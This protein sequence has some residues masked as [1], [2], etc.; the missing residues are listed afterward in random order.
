MAIIGQIYFGLYGKYIFKLFFYDIIE[1]FE[2]NL[3]GIFLWDNDLPIVWFSLCVYLKS[4][5]TVSTDCKGKM[6]I[7]PRNYKLD[8]IWLI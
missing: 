5:M 6:N 3:F 8:L 4:K 2:S 7:C 1:P